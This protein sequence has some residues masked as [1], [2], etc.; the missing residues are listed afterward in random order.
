M[1]PRAGLDA[2][3][4]VVVVVVV[5]VVATFRNP[6]V[7]SHDLSFVCALAKQL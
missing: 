1:Y 4:K 2:V 5:V 6:K 7:Q 3:A